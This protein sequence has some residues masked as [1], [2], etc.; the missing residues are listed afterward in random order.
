MYLFH[1][2]FIDHVNITTK[3]NYD[4][5]FNPIVRKGRIILLLPLAIFSAYEQ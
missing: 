2:V 5:V 3:K 4:N 1:F